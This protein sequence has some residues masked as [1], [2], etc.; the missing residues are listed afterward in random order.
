MGID[1][2]RNDCFSGGVDHHGIGRDRHRSFAPDALNPAVHDRDDGVRDGS[3]SG[4]I[5]QKAASDH[6]RSLIRLSGL[7]L[8]T[9]GG[10]DQRGYQRNCEE[11]PGSPNVKAPLAESNTAT[12]AA[13]F[14][15]QLSGSLDTPA[16]VL[17]V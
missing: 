3:R 9:S 10:R 12:R 11:K 1:Q 6:E 7:V 14:E 15:I 4:S 13:L 2:S 16:G 17:R 5:D 8:S